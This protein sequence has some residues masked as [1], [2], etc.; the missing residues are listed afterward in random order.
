MP[1]TQKEDG[2][3][4]AGKMGS[5]GIRNW[6]FGPPWPPARRS[7]GSESATNFRTFDVS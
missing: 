1:R 4:E 3:L 6:E 7:Y 5:N 2:S